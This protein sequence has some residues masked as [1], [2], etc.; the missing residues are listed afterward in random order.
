MITARDIEAVYPLSP[1]QQGMMFHVLD[2]PSTGL[3]HLHATYELIGML[4]CARFES[5]WSRVLARHAALR[6]AIVW[7]RTPRMMQVVMRKAELPIKWEDWRSLGAAGQTKHLEEFLEDDR[8]R[9]F[10]L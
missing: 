5:A 4:D 7:Q 1:M 3:Y 2:A 6:T 9:G 10:D 8:H